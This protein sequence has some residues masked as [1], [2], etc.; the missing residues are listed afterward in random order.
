MEQDQK[1]AEHPAAAPWPAG[2]GAHAFLTLTRAE[3][4]PTVFSNCVAG[5]WLGGGG[6]PAN[7]FIVSGG[8]ILVFLGASLLSH[9]F[10]LSFDRQHRREHAAP[11]GKVGLRT[12]WRVGLL[13]LV[14]GTIGMQWPGRVTGGLAMILV[15]VAVLRSS[16]HRLLPFSPELLGLCRFLLYVLGASTA[17]RGITGNAMWCG[18]ALAIYVS[19]FE[20]L[21]AR[22]SGLKRAW[23]VTALATP[24]VLAG[25][26]NAG[27][28]M[29]TAAMLGGI[30]LCWT[31]LS[32]HSSLTAAAPAQAGANLFT[33]GMVL[34]DILAACPAPVAQWQAAQ[35]APRDLLQVFGALFFSSLALLL[36]RSWA[37]R[38]QGGNL[39]L[40]ADQKQR[41]EPNPRG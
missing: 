2:T 12:L 33:C 19:G 31:V 4:L 40:R 5:W 11:L 14:F 41:L 28:Y 21:D 25:L 23:Q 37:A 3:Q 34:A 13:L 7:L 20:S 24:L 32:W 8:A 29:P 10:G 15:F 22:D 30:L 9:A 16:M 18:I 26:M 38:K 6:N 27:A 36:T 35:S 17:S 39:P 1:A